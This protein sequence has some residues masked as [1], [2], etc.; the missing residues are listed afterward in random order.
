MPIYDYKCLSCNKEKE[1]IHSF[2]R[3]ME[4]DMELQREFKDSF[5]EDCKGNCEIHKIISGNFS[6]HSASTND[7]RKMNFLNRGK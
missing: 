7:V 6:V 2:S 1:M 4:T 5:P 3:D